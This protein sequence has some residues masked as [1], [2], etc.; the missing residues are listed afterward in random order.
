M[1]AIS[2]LPKNANGFD[3]GEGVFIFANNK[4]V[5]SSKGAREHITVHFGPTSQTLDVHKTSITTGGSTTRVTL[6]SSAP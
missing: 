4:L 1:P 6:F 5:V 3:F 2:S